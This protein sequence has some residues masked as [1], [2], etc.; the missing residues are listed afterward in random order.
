MKYDQ[1]STFTFVC[2]GDCYEIRLHGC[3]IAGITRYM[4][5]TSLRQELEYSDLSVE[6]QDRIL[7]KVHEILLE[8]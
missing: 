6:V 2:S 4:N 5:G 8:T 1:Q 3:T 7:A